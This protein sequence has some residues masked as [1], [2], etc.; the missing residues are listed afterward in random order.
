MTFGKIWR[1]TWH[2]L[3][4]NLPWPLVTFARTRWS[5]STYFM[6]SNMNQFAARFRGGLVHVRTPKK[7]SVA[8]T[9]SLVNP[10]FRCI[11]TKKK[12]AVNIFLPKSIYIISVIIYFQQVFY[13][14]VGI[15]TGNFFFRKLDLRFRLDW[16]NAFVRQLWQLISSSSSGNMIKIHCGQLNSNRFEITLG[17]GD[18]F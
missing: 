11:A 13:F 16:T 3:W 15:F 18:S 17:L 2:Y 9:D 14:F 5:D 4:W 1:D 6:C 8:W 12:L 7:G 10:K